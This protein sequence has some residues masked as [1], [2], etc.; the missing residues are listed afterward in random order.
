MSSIAARTN[1]VV[2]HTFSHAPRRRDEEPGGVQEVNAR[3]EQADAGLAE[4]HRPVE[5]EKSNLKEWRREWVLSETIKRGEAFIHL[6]GFERAVTSRVELLC[7][8]V[9]H[10]L[11]LRSVRSDV[12]LGQD[13]S[14]AVCE[15][16]M[17]SRDHRR[18]AAILALEVL[19]KNRVPERSI[20]IERLSDEARDQ[21]LELCLAS[22]LAK[23]DRLDVLAHVEVGIVD[24]ARTVEAT[25]QVRQLLLVLGELLDLL[26]DGGDE[27]VE[28]H[29][30]VGQST[31]EER[32]YLDNCTLMHTQR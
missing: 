20:E 19:D 2:G 10:L 27:L 1:M 6:A 17:S 26:L 8:A 11:D 18:V 3:P 30:C 32:D 28:R 21:R 5:R 31:R 22:W 13:E 4:R 14:L 29:A 25:I 24:E 23:S 15:G 16:M 9:H 7:T 12:E